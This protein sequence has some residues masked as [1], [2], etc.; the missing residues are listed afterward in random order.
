VSYAAVDPAIAGWATTNGLTLCTEWDGRPHRFCY[1]SGGEHECF[2]ISIEP[3]RDG[4]IYIH[5][6]EIETEGDAELH[7]RWNVPMA[8]LLPALEAA[9]TQIRTWSRGHP[10]GGGAGM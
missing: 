9:M 1:V 4:K 2:Q 10:L 3:P 5:A 7:E 6:R 8:D